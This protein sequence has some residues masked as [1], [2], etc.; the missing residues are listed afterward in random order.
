MDNRKLENIVTK[1]GVA[2]LFLS[3]FIG[4]ILVF[5]IAFN[6]DLFS[7]SMKRAVWVFLGLV[8]VFVFSSVLISLMLNVSRIAKTV[9]VISSRQEMHDVN[10]TKRERAAVNN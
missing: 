6:I 8:C 9:D 4:I 3:T 10:E 1:T 7:N 5:D 2:L